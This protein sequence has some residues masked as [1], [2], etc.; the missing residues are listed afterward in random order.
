[1]KSRAV[2]EQDLSVLREEFARTD[3]AFLV[4]FRGLKV[5]AVDDLR[6]R[7]RDVNGTYRVVKNTLARRASSGTSLEPLADSF[8]GP[9]AVVT[10]ETDVPVVAKALTDFAKGRPEL[11]FRAGVVGGT[12]LDEAGC[13]AI[14]DVPSREELQSKL[15]WVLQ[16]PL[17]GLAT[18]LNAPAR[19]LA[20]VLAEVG[21]KQ[22]GAGES[23]G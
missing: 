4:D 3:A 16:S 14:A 9:T 17:Q 5:V 1:M 7:I 18:V 23:A 11:R 13:K 15:A 20:V 2:K 12:V 22:E 10:A 6:R 8:S 19:D 21:K